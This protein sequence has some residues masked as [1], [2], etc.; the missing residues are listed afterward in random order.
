M[1]ALLFSKF[2]IFFFPKREENSKFH[3]TDIRAHIDIHISLSLFL[4]SRGGGK[5]EIK[6]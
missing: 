4:S 5:K 6:S 1:R 2:S 3:F